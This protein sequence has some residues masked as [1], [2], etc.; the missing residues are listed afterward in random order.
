[1][2][3]ERFLAELR[4]AIRVLEEEEIQDIIGEYE[5]HIDLKVQKGQTVEQAI[6]DFGNLKELATEILEG[7]HVNVDF[8][9]GDEEKQTKK[10]KLPSGNEP[11]QKFFGKGKEGILVA[12][13]GI[14]H[15]FIW[16]GK[17]VRRPF[18][19][20]S[21]KLILG[22]E[23]HKDKELSK[24]LNGIGVWLIHNLKGIGKMMLQLGNWLIRI[25]VWC[26]RLLWN[27]GVIAAALVSGAMGLFVLFMV[28]ILGVLLLQ[29]YPLIG[30]TVGCLGLVL[31]LLAVTLLLWTM[32]WHEPKVKQNGEKPAESINSN[33]T[34]VEGGSYA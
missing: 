10:E 5:Q 14:A 17:Q 26:L 3:K 31:C 15:S 34:E 13:N 29:G 18:C 28:G 23:R 12:G 19:W 7:Y 16:L 24:K 4:K 32:F 22:R 11:L 20:I 30:V 1:M 33:F 25:S 9:V 2:D 8:V 27:G 21:K 6:A